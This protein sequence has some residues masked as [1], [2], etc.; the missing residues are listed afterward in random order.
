MQP[1]AKVLRH[2]EQLGRACY[3]VLL[4]ELVLQTRLRSRYD[5]ARSGVT[6]RTA[7]ALSSTMPLNRGFVPLVSLPWP[8][9]RQAASL[10]QSG[11]NCPSESLNARANVAAELGKQRARRDSNPRPSD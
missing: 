10:E 9:G 8:S 5:T 1:D 6:A 7:I 3:L 2:L 4:G 11:W